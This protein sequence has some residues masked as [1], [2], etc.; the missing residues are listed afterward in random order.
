MAFNHQG[1]LRVHRYFHTEPEKFKCEK[2]G[3][4]LR[5]GESLK[6]HT[7]RM[8]REFE[9]DARPF[10]CEYEGC[11]ST[12]KFK[13]YLRLHVREVHTHRRPPRVRVKKKKNVQEEG[14]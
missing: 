7:E 12:F 2:C 10:A 11:S 13:D 3:A 8:H 5:N 6:K 4:C 1:A 14:D 9:S